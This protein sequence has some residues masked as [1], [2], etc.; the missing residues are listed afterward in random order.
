MNSRDSV[1]QTREGTQGDHWRY[2]E[3][4]ALALRYVSNTAV[5]I[6]ITVPVGSQDYVQSRFLGQQAIRRHMSHQNTTKRQGQEPSTEQ[7][8]YAVDK[9]LIESRSGLREDWKQQVLCIGP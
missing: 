6:L 3:G 8:W 5:P 2:E 9:L 4:L 7:M 1:E